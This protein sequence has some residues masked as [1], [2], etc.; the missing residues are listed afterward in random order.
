[1]SEEQRQHP[2]PDAPDQ[3]DAWLRQHL[4]RRL[5]I[6]LMITT[7]DAVG[8]PALAHLL[9]ALREYAEMR[10]LPPARLASQDAVPDATDSTVAAAPQVELAR[11]D[12]EVV[13]VWT[14]PGAAA[15]GAAYACLEHVGL[16][17]RAF[18]ALIGP[19][20]SRREARV[21]GF[22][23]GYPADI[24]VETLAMRLAHEGV[25]IDERRRR[26]SSPPCYL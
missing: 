3:V 6:A 7:P 5:T 12:P 14:H 1:M 26:G 20:I 18:V 19:G 23:D 13:L 15:T 16:L 11:L 24:S 2:T 25:A 8:A 9:T 17:D 22:E 4:G 21:L 10:I